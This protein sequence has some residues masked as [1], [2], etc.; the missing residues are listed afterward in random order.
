[1]KLKSD[2]HRISLFLLHWGQ[3]SVSPDCSPRSLSDAEQSHGCLQ[4]GRRAL[5]VLAKV[6]S[7]H[8][9]EPVSH[10]GCTASRLHHLPPSCGGRLQECLDDL[11]LSMC[12]RTLPPQPH[13]LSNTS[14]T[15]S[16]NVR[17]HF[18]ISCPLAWSWGGSAL[19]ELGR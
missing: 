19:V 8:H 14:N 16:N 1:M 12:L 11:A 10:V 6:Y 13:R 2:I 15:T 3:S 17:P 4:K 5:C 7:A 9:P 18:D